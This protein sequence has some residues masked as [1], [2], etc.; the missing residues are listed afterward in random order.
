M[1]A[2]PAPDW[3]VV[4]IY[5]RFLRLVGPSRRSSQDPV[6]GTVYVFDVRTMRCLTRAKDE[7]CLNA[8]SI[9]A[10]P[11]GLSLA[12]GRVLAG[13][14]TSLRFPRRAPTTPVLVR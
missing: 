10:S 9:A 12:A 6:T 5:A 4:R 8:T 2:L 14:Y 3:S 1:P 13:P 7:G 11:D